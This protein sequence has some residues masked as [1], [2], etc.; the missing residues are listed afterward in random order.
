M[1]VVRW[2]AIMVRL[3]LAATA[4]CAM[5]GCATTTPEA[6]L[7]NE[8]YWDA[9]VECESRYRTL[10]LDQ[11]DREGNVTMHADAESRHELRPFIEC[12]QT[13]VRARIDQRRRTGQPLPDSVNESPAAEID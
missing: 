11:I 2:E 7:T 8:I 6:R 9:A 1:D 13:G 5:T 10:H 3:L 4:L 12:Y